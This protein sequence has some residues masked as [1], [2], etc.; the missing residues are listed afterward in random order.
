MSDTPHPE[1]KNPRLRKL[2]RYY[3]G[4]AIL[5]L[6]TLLVF[7]IGNVLLYC[8]LVFYHAVKTNPERDF[9]EKSLAVVYPDLTPQDRNA[10]IREM[11]ERPQVYEDFVHFKE[12]PFAGRF[13]NVSEYG[14]RKSKN[15]GPW[16][17]DSR[18][19]NVFTFGGSTMFGWALPDEQTIA[20][21][22]QEELSRHSQRPVSVYNFG[23][24]AYYSTQECILLEQLLSKGYKPDIAIFLDGLNEFWQLEDTP[25][26]WPTSN[27]S[28]AESTFSSLVGDLPMTRAAGAVRRLF[29]GSRS[30]SQHEITATAMHVV[31]RYQRHERTI[32]S[33]CR[34]FDVAPVFVW[35]PVPTYKYDLSYHLLMTDDQRQEYVFH[36]V[37]YAEMD[38]R[39][40]RG[41][42]GSD[43]L[44]SAD[45][46]QDEKECVY[47]DACHYTAR[48]SRKLAQSIGTACVERGLL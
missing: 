37:G 3:R 9:P 13:V 17:P 43:F 32:R 39:E 4:S 14:F 22:L 41:E 35:Q 44:W 25:H 36:N 27:R 46:Q 24:N 31:D 12:R 45:L 34:A 16:P 11:W 40:R 18:N 28:L 33:I 42:L 21:Y 5:L 10:M 19:V 23:V 30:P 48:F 7:M 29:A 15:Q 1:L 47:V 26:P 2:I 6:N 8:A 20:S 38:R